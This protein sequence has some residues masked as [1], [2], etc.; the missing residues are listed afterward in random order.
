MFVLRRRDRLWIASAAT[1]ALAS[2][3]GAS[4]ALAGEAAP[5]ASQ[6]AP[7]GDESFVRSVLKKANM[8]TDDVGHP[9][10]F[11]VK[12]RPAAPADYVPVFR[13]NDEHK[14]KV[15]TPDQLKAMEAELDS[16]SAHHAQIRDAFPPARRAFQEEERDKAAKAAAKHA[17]NPAE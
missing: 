17:K 1:L 11:V 2:A 13:K 5:A 3:A 9:Q 8:A 14:T 15:L 4:A 12:S 6:S 16:A 10:D 7:G